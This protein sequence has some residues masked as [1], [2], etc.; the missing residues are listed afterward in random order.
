VSAFSSPTKRSGGSA[1]AAFVWDDADD[2]Q[3]R[4]KEDAKQQTPKRSTHPGSRGIFRC[5]VFFI[6]FKVMTPGERE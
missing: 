4:A 6:L 1:W 5:I 3:E 2:G